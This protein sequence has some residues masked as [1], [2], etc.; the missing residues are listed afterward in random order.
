[1]Y[2][3]YEYIY[4]YIYIYNNIEYHNIRDHGTK[5]PRDHRTTGP[6]DQGTKGPGDQGDRKKKR[7]AKKKTKKGVKKYALHFRS[8]KKY[9][10]TSLVSLMQTEKATE[11]LI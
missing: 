4:I 5:G 9:H 6:E 1:M 7:G 11:S 3:M 10:H 8:L 2:D